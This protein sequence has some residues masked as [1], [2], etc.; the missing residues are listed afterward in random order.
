VT[1]TELSLIESGKEGPFCQE[2]AKATG[3]GRQRRVTGPRPDG[4]VTWVRAG[5]P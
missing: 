1:V 4:L 3:S 2:G 5:T